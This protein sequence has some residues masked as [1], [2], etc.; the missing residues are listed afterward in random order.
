MRLKCRDAPADVD[1]LIR[2]EMKAVAE[3]A[4]G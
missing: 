2:E 3:S 4:N 1:P